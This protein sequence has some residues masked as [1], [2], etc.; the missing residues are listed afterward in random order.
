MVKEEELEKMLNNV[1]NLID[2]NLDVST[3]TSVL[4]NEE[5]DYDTELKPGGLAKG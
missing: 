4:N 2:Y 3:A 5:K 1:D